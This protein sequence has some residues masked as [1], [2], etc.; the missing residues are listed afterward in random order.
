MVIIT[1]LSALFDVL[2]VISGYNLRAVI[3]CHGSYDS[4]A[5][6]RFANKQSN[7]SDLDTDVRDL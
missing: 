2:F 4:I 7:Y 3:L 6:I 5:F 1:Q